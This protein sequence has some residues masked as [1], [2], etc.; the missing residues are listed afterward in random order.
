MTKAE[1]HRERG[2]AA[3][4]TAFEDA[5]AQAL[6]PQPAPAHLRARIM[7]RVAQAADD[8]F[9]GA[10]L[11]PRLALGAAAFACVCVIGGFAA[12]GLVFDGS[13]GFTGELATLTGL[14]DET[15]VLEDVL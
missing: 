1:H 3:R 8:A 4:Q 9:P 10:M 2:T 13:T 11:R 5:L 15:S 6:S 7:A 14:A 12:G